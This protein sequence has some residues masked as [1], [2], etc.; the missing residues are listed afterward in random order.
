MNQPHNDPQSELNEIKNLVQVLEERMKETKPGS[1][2]GALISE[3]NK[4]ELRLNYLRKL[5]APLSR[6]A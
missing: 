3:L 1:N 6:A 5:Y 2:T 4:I